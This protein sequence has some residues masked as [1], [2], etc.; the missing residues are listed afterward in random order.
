MASSNVS[1]YDKLLKEIY[2]DVLNISDSKGSDVELD[3]N[4]CNDCSGENIL[5]DED[6][7]AVSNRLKRNWLLINEQNA[8][9]DFLSYVILYHTLCGITV[10]FCLCFNRI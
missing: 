8:K 3:D 6:S 4:Y 10:K 7:N 5:V 9:R 1:N 2:R